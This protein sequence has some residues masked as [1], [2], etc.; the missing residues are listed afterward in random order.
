MNYPLS[1]QL[2]S[3]FLCIYVLKATGANVVAPKS[4]ENSF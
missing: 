1:S 2:A 4:V 3:W